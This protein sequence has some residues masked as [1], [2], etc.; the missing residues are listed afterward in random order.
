MRFET[1]L[2]MIIVGVTRCG[3]THYL[4][5]MLENDYK[6]HFEYIFLICPTYLWNK[7]YQEWEYKGDKKFF[8]FFAEKFLE[9]VTSVFGGTNSLIIL[10]DCASSQYVKNSSGE[11]VKL[12]FSA[13]HYGF[14]TIIITQQLTWITKPYRVNTQILVTFYN[15]DKNDMRT[16]L[17][18]SVDSTAEEYRDIKDKLKK[19]EYSTL[20]VYRRPPWGHRIV[21]SQ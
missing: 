18:E 15:P 17:E 8:P 9:Y 20:E 13:R 3:K 11:I 2:N 7:T 14:S 5:K 21:Y 1:P 6:G 12:A 16:L 19:N 4:L 10:D